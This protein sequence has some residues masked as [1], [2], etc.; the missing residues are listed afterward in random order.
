[1]SAFDSTGM[2]EFIMEFYQTGGALFS[3][4]GELTLKDERAYE[5]FDRQLG[6]SSFPLVS[7]KSRYWDL[8]RERTR[9]MAKDPEATFGRLFGEEFRQAYEEQFRELKAKRRSRTPDQSSNEHPQR[10]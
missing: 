1:M 6:K 3:E 7:V 4:D 8:Y 9:E 10:R 2:G 5:A